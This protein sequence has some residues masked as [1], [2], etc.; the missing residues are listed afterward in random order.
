[1]HKS[2]AA[3]PQQSE[4]AA[5]PV[6]RVQSVPIAP[7]LPPPPAAKT[8]AAPPAPVQRPVPVT[9]KALISETGP[10]LRSGLTWRVY[11][12]KVSTEGSGF[13]LL[14]T[15]REA[16]PTAALLPGE[17]LVNAAY[18]LSNLTR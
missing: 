1:V 7:P 18:G 13:K 4:A 6:N 16:M 14:N 11:A 3:P 10:S 2:A 9:F 12:S 8:A 15:H 5:P 17:Y